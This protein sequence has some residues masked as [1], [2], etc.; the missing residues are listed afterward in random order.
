[1]SSS[2]CCFLKDTINETKRLPSEWE[3]L[4]AN[5]AT[6]KGFISKMYNRLFI[7]IT[8]KQATQ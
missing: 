1:M 4:F 2:N 8:K 6:D 3:R 5:D 7:S